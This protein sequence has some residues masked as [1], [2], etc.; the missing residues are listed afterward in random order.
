MVVLLLILI[1]VEL[2]PSSVYCSYSACLTQNECETEDSTKVP[3]GN[4]SQLTCVASLSSADLSPF[5][6]VD[7]IKSELWD[8][9]EEQPFRLN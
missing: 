6:A 5:T 2:R 4:A 7:L 3:K 1:R 9:K 8:E